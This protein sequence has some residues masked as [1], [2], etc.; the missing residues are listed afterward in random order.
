M[1]MAELFADPLAVAGSACEI[2]Y[3]IVDSIPSK[4]LSA[5]IASSRARLDWAPESCTKQRPK[6]A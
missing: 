2:S 3:N 5:R 1:D 4:S 6:I